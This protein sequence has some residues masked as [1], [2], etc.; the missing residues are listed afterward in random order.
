MSWTSVANALDAPK[1]FWASIL[2]PLEETW[3][4]YVSFRVGM[5]MLEVSLSTIFRSTW[6][7]TALHPKLPYSD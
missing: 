2:T 5:S 6:L 4:E 1:L 3:S 7:R